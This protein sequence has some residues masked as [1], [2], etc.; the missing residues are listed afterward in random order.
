MAQA[1]Y[2]SCSGCGRLFS[3]ESKAEMDL[4]LSHDCDDDDDE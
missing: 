3:A 1:G 2:E 4:L